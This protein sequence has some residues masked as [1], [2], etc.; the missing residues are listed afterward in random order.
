MRNRDGGKK[1]R[2]IEEEER[3][4]EKQDSTDYEKDSYL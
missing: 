2:G 4:K 3:R 1:G